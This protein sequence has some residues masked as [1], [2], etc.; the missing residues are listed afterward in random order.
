MSGRPPVRLR[1]MIHLTISLIERL[2]C[3]SSNDRSKTGVRSPAALRCTRQRGGPDLFDVASIGYVLH[4][5]GYDSRS[6][7]QA[8]VHRPWSSKIQ[9][10]ARS[11]LTCAPASNLQKTS[12]RDT[13]QHPRT[14]LLGRQPFQIN[15]AV[16]ALLS[17]M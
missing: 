1:F 12:Q 2:R 4:Q 13:N 6:K 8:P 14:R 11:R 9:Q 17:D 15:Y 3:C 16:L 10:A 7:L 5:S